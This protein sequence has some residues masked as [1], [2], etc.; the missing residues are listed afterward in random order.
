MKHLK[1]RREGALARLQPN[2]VAAEKELNKTCAA[3]KHKEVSQNKRKKKEYEIAIQALQN[4]IK[5]MQYEDAVLRTR[6]QAM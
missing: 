6:L 2:M 3:A 5:R 1:K 4:A